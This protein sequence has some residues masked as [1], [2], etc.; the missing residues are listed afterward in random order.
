M[1]EK[2]TGEI[3]APVMDSSST[4]DPVATPPRPSLLAWPALPS[5]LAVLLLLWMVSV[6]TL[7]Q[8]TMSPT[9]DEQNHVTRGIA[10]L[11]TGDYRLCYH[12]PPL[13]N[14][15]QGLPVAW[16]NDTHFTT[17]IPGWENTEIWP[18]SHETVWHNAKNGDR[19]IKLA[20]IPTL[21]FALVLAL[22]IFF[23]A[24]ELFGPWGGVLSLTLFAID[25]NFIAHSGLATTDVPAAA[26]IA[27]ALFAL[28]RYVLRPSRGRLLW[29][30]IAIGL[31]LAAKFSGLILVPITGLLLL[32]LSCWPAADAGLPAYWRQFPFWGRVGRAFGVYMLLGVLAAITLWGVYGFKVEALGSKPGHP[33]AADAGWKAHLPVPAMQYFRGLKTVATQAEEHPAYL[34]GQTSANKKGWWYY[35]PVA[36]AAKTPIPALFLLLGALVLLAIPVSRRHLG[37]TRLSMLFLLLPI[38]IFSLAAMGFLGI[39]LNL[40]IRHILPLYPFLLILAGGWVRLPARTRWY[41]WAIGCLLAMQLASVALSFPD[42]IAYFNE[43]AGGQ[44]EGYRVLADSNLDWGQDLQRLAQWQRENDVYPLAFSY[45]GTT[46]PQVYG[47]KYVPF[48]GFGIMRH[49]P[50]P[51]LATFRGFLAVSA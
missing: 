27:L 13:A 5:V 41:P 16:R 11:R 43:V 29:A 36:F 46:P 34:L 32:I 50:A 22:V 42:Y 28:Y 48:S 47:L 19:L 7:S 15:L 6:T 9:Y 21:L 35:F 45:F 26:T 17:N 8:L 2:E 51:N 20:R 33:V 4:A 44:D 3:S 31:A 49:C 30:G 39:S 40:G 23:W 38:V 25:P 12:H 24:R 14:I 1:T 37:L 18:A 10:I